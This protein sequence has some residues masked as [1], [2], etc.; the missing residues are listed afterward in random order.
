MDDL[1]I[2]KLR[3]ALSYSAPA[4]LLGVWAL[5]AFEDGWVS[6]IILAV[7]FGVFAQGAA[8]IAYIIA[9]YISARIA[10]KNPEEMTFHRP[11]YQ[12]SGA[13]LLVA[14]MYMLGQHWRN[15]AEETV[16]RCV[17]EETGSTNPFGQF[18]NAPDLVHYCI[19]EYGHDYMPIDD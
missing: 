17:R 10:D 7:L 14:V 19:N 13:V 4:L 9:V 3:Q 12:M 18:T 5:V 1:R 11:D 8:M 16:V 2:M 15:E 6:R